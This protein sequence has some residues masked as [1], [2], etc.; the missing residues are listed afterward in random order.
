MKA[1]LINSYSDFNKGDLGILEGTIHSLKEANKSIEIYSVS[2]FN[3]NDPFFVSHHSELR[4]SVIEVYPAI[5]G[6]LFHKNNNSL[7]MAFKLFLDLF[8]MFFIYFGPF[9]LF[10]KLIFNQ[11]EIETLKLIKNSDVVISKGGS[12]ICNDRGLKGFF[13]FTREMSILIIAI[14]LNKK[15]AI[16]GQSIGP[17]YGRLSLKLVNHILRKASK[18]V[19]RE[20]NC[21]KNFPD[22]V[23][24]TTVIQGYDLAFSLPTDALNPSI[25]QQKK[26]VGITVKRFSSKKVDDL[27]SKIIVQAIEFIITTLNK[28][29]VILPHVTID[30]DV[31]KAF[32]IYSKLP[33]KLKSDISV[34]TNDYTPTELL[35]MYNDLEFLIGTRLHSTIFSMV[36]NT[37][38]INIAYHGTKASGVFERFNMDNYVIEG[39][40]LTFDALKDRILMLEARSIE[41][42]KFV[43][44]VTAAKRI[45]IEIA[46]QI[47]S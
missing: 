29:V 17:V 40:S 5:I 43:E 38:V 6:R 35:E 34:F 14:R 27:Y 25:L 7:V 33:D 32:E 41:D 45:N 31:S 28:R 20:K 1:V 9:Y 3:Y 11:S 13:R 42:F 46:K 2:S 15:L 26:T 4:K 44:N 19:I 22:I 30:D 23:F 8:K 21:V 18:V 16:W 39:N 37:K 12:F 36:V 24:P 47:L 10:R